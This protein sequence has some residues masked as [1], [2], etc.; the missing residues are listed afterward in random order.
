V[1]STFEIFV[2]ALL[3][4]RAK[5]GIIVID[6]VSLSIVLGLI[7]MEVGSRL[8]VLLAEGTAL[9]LIV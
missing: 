6:T 4:D 8:G 2:G 1:G 9:G 3:I 5:L 7:E